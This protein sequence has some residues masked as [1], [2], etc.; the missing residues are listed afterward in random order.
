VSRFRHLVTT[1]VCAL[2]VSTSLLA[3]AAKPAPAAPAKSAP[4][5][6]AARGKYLVAIMSCSDCH[7]PMKMG[8]KGP[9]PDMARLFSGHPAGMQLPP[10]PPPSGPWGW[11]GTL[12]NTAFAGPWGISY[13]ANLTPDQNTGLGIWTEEMFMKAM[14]TGK[15]MGTSREIKPPMP[16]NWIG[17]ATD[18]DLKAIFAYLKSMPA[19]SN[20]VP[21]VQEPPSAPGPGKAAPGAGPANAPKGT[22]KKTS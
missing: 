16:W 11:S 21:D 4:A 14:R 19:I 3:Q 6:A 10:P 18:D 17:M 5:S 22:P 20:R 8:A 13:S 9:E 15:H 2:A 1:S 12:T 7:T